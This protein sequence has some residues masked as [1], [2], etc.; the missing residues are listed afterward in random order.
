MA[1]I[2]HSAHVSR[3]HSEVALKMGHA[4]IKVRTRACGRSFIVR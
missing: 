2:E 1:K 4:Q 3:L